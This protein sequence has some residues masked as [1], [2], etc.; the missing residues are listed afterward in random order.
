[1]GNFGIPNLK[2][3]S[4]LPG[5]RP[6]QKAHGQGG[7]VQSALFPGT[8]DHSRTCLLGH[9]SADLLRGSLCVYNIRT[10]ITDCITSSL[11]RSIRLCGHGLKL[12]MH[13]SFLTFRHVCALFCELF[14]EIV[15]QSLYTSHKITDFI[16]LWFCEKL[17]E[18]T[19]SGVKSWQICSRI[20]SGCGVF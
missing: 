7:G 14:H 15:N 11:T 5:A 16:Y 18:C 17:D 3:I 8:T 10:Y 2:K 20:H 19:N 13:L 9:S 1:M 4:L 6:H 12:A